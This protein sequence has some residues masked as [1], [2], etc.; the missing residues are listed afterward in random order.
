MVGKTIGHYKIIDKLGEGGMGE[1]FLAHDTSL[2]RKVALKFLPDFLQEDPTA[3]KHLLWE[4]RAP[5]LQDIP[6]FESFGKGLHY[7]TPPS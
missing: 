5:L 1:V 7:E 4:A 3:R 2:D 6:E